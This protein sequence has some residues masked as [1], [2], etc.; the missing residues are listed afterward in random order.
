MNDL[1][2]VI[3]PVYNTEQYIEKS[4]QSVLA[5]TYHNLEIIVIDDGSTDGS[6]EIVKAYAEGDPRVLIHSIPNS[7]VSAARN[8]GIELSHGEYI[9]FIDSDDCI[10]PFFCER[11]YQAI[12][13][14]DISIC[15]VSVPTKT[16]T[17][18]THVSQQSKKSAKEYLCDVMGMK[19]SAHPIWNKLIRRNILIDN[20]LRFEEG[21]YFEDMIMSS[22]LAI[23]IS[24]V[25]YINE[26]LYYYYIHEKSIMTE[27]KDKLAYDYLYAN[28]KVFKVLEEG[29]LIKDL[30]NTF[31]E[32][33]LYSLYQINRMMFESSKI[34]FEAFKATVEGLLE[35]I[36]KVR[37]I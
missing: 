26:D 28:Y 18:F 19:Y 3:I 31:L 8:A 22:Q 17:S 1:I 15:G 4:I 32:S 9:C 20:G 7:G 27:K 6:I 5:Q 37:Y 21:R 25:T 11:L 34:S 36:Y 16:K 13:D 29:G 33:L 30:K 24:N 12:G 14:S 2:S 35:M 10:S 23:H